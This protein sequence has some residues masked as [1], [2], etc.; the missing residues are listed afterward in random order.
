M[1]LICLKTTNLP[2]MVEHTHIKQQTHSA[3]HPYLVDV[4]RCSRGAWG[5]YDVTDTLA[6]FLL[7]S[8]SLGSLGSG[9]S[10]KLF[11][12][13]S[14]DTTALSAL[15]LLDRLGSGGNVFFFLA[16][17]AALLLLG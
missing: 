2:W 1:E 12:E 8:G 15:R 3:L 16:H 5:G 10:K 11:F 6:N 13:T 17:H 14:N 4:A 9:A 7:S